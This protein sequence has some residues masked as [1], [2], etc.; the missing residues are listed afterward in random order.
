VRAAV[1]RDG[2][3][4]VEERELPDVAGDRVL[5]EVTS[6]GV[7]RADLLQLRG[8]HPA[9]PGWPADI[10]GLEFSGVVAAAG[11]GV[12]SVAK[13]DEIF[14]IIGGGAHATHLVTPEA[15]C[16][17]LPE[18]LD[19]V[20]AGGVPEVFMT[21]YDALVTR[22]R[23]ASGERVLING[24]GS[25]VGTAAVQIAR[26]L[27]A[28]TVGTARTADKLERAQELGLDDAI[29]AGEDMSRGIGEVDVVIELVGGHYLET[30]VVVCRSG[31][32]IV[33]VGLLAGSS[34]DLD[35]RA[36]MRKRLTLVGTVLRNRPEW[37]K[38]ELSARFSKHVAPLFTS[39]ALRPVVDRTV[40]LE[41]VPEAYEALG[42]NRTFGKIVLTM[43]G[44]S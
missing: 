16:V 34:V 22:G 11:D 13:G 28:R 7:N 1:I 8:M 37:E 30:D 2:R 35:L 3:V 10:P 5:V 25:G 40:D 23:L 9:P 26:A 36:L 15:L 4:G 18:G 21:A 38:A 24:A 14:G 44:R 6:S 42:S 19:P 20:E 33:V 31:G 29:V 17:P 27:G 43:G 32:R 39:G 41:R 12:V